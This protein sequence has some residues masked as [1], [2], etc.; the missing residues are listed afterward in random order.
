MGSTLIR[1]AVIMTMNE[2]DEILIGDVLVTGNQIT[3]IGS[4]IQATDVD[5]VIEAGGKVLP[6]GFIQTHIHLCQ[7]LFRGRADDLELIDWLR[8][9]IWPLEAPIMQILSTIRRCL[10]LES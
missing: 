9:R 6:P 5:R 7:T 8:T 3:Q 2:T 10:V 1:N 4:N